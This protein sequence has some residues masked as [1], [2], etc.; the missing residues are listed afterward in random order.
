[1]RHE[2]ISISKA[3]AKLLEL[4]RKVNE[5]GRAFL[6]VKDG[7]TM[8]VIVPTEEY[9]ALIESQEVLANSETMKSLKAALEDEKKSRVWKRDQNGKWVKPGKKKKVA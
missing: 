2:I 1:M 3:K 6:I 8:G 7:N 9:E 5:E 4:M